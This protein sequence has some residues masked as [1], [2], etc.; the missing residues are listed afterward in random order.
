MSETLSHCEIETGILVEHI[1]NITVPN[2]YLTV[3]SSEEYL[4]YFTRRQRIVNVAAKDEKV[5]DAVVTTEDATSDAEVES[6][7]LVEACNSINATFLRWDTIWATCD[8][9]EDKQLY[10][11]VHD[12]EVCLGGLCQDATEARKLKVASGMF[13]ELMEISGELTKSTCKL[14]SEQPQV[15]LWE[16]TWAQL[17][18]AVSVVVAVAVIIFFCIHQTLSDRKRYD[19]S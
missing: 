14:L 2:R 4:Y 3:I 7:T 12:F 6:S 1:P 15:P 19:T 11:Q 10:F 17:A 13:S 5:N 9:E 8:G 18:A 16:R